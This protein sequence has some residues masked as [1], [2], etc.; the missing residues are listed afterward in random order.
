[1]EPFYLAEIRSRD[2]LPYYTGHLNTVEST[3][4]IA[5]APVRWSRWAPRPEFRSCQVNQE[6]SD[7]PLDP[8]LYRQFME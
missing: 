8:A 2:F 4:P 6:M 7:Q 3:R 5:S 1:V